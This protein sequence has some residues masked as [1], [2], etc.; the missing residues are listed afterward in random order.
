MEADYKH[1]EPQAASNQNE[2]G[3]SP[4]TIDLVLRIANSFPAID[5][6]CHAAR[7]LVLAH[8]Q[9]TAGETLFFHPLRTH[10][11]LGVPLTL[12]QQVLA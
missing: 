10:I 5:A 12:A 6:Y 2:W 3:T 8:A 1:A 9:V 4:I 11:Q 7:T